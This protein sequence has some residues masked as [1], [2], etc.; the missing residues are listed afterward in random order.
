M[1]RK[2][3]NKERSNIMSQVLTTMLILAAL[4]Y[5]YATYD[6]GVK[7]V[8]SRMTWLD[9]ENHQ[10]VTKLNYT[11]FAVL[12][13]MAITELVSSIGEYEGGI[14]TILLMLWILFGAYLIPNILYR[15][16]ICKITSMNPQTKKGEENLKKLYLYAKIYLV[17]SLITLLI[18]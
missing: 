11:L 16:M 12:I 5:F 3:T 7:K 10:S 4:V 2:S 6:E 1:I 17:Y 9:I 18:F 8:E 14:T 15:L 13:A